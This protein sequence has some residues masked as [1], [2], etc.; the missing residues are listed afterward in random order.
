MCYVWNRMFQKVH[1]VNIITGINESKRLKK[2]TWC[3]YKFNFDST[4]WSVKKCEC[5]ENHIGNPATCRC[6]NGKYVRSIIDHSVVICGEIIQETKA[7]PTKAVT[8][9]STSAGFYIWLSFLLITLT[10]LIASSIYCYLIKYQAKQKTL[11]N[12]Y[13]T[14]S[15]LKEARYWKF[16][17]KWKVTTN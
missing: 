5:E 8:T 10:S 13:Y 1:V 12:C 3:K 4:K 16:I 7:V 15:K 14:I 17:I 6:K 11:L 9:N 2:H